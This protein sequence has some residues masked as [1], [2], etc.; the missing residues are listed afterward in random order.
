MIL[1]ST[2]DMELSS[3]VVIIY[4]TGEHNKTVLRKNHVDSYTTK[5]G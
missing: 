1:N 4:G 5:S 2:A 3:M